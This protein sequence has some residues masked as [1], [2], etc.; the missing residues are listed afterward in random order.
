MGKNKTEKINS[1]NGLLA[2]IIRKGYGTEGVNFV[3]PDNFP[4][5]LGM[6]LRK[7]G[8]FIKPHKHVPFDK[9]LNIP[10]QEFI[11]V[12]S[13][14]VQI[15]IFEGNKKIKKVSLSGG[16]MILLNCAHD[17]KCVEKTKMIEI[18]QGPYRGKQEEKRFLK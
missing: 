9:L 6:H 7:K 15:N 10:V 14:R 18:K 3:S 11:Y 13:G 2:I 16:D 12:E 8:D 17:L 5:Q 4:L 1:K